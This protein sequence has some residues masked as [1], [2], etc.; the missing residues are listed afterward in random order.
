MSPRAVLVA[1][2]V[3]LAPPVNASD[4]TTGVLATAAPPGPTPELVEMTGQLRLVL[5]RRRPGVLDAAAL[6]ERMSHPSTASL[7][8]LDRA[9][10][11]SVAAYLNGDYEGSVRTLHAILEDLEKMPE[12]RQ[13]FSQWTRAMLRLASTELDLDRRDAANQV[14]DRLVRADPGVQVDPAQHPP[15]L[16][17]LIEA[18]RSRLR[19]SPGAK[20]TVKA[21]ESARV[22]VDGREVGTTPLVVTLARGRYRVTGVRQA[23]H[24]PAVQVDLT[25]GDRSVTLDFTVAEMLLPDKGPGLALPGAERLR[26]LVAAGAF[27]RLDSILAMSLLDDAGA[28]YLVGSLHDVRRGM[29]VREGRVRLSGRSLPSDGAA[30]LADFFVTGKVS[31]PVEP[32]LSISADAPRTGGKSKALGWTAF[33]TGVTMIGLGGV[34]IWQA[35]SSS[36]SYDSA[37]KL[38]QSDGRVLP[39]DQ[40]SYSDH[41]SAGDAANRRAIGIGIGA[42]VCAATTVVLGYLAYRQTGEIGPFRF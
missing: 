11:G 6:R 35:I 38:L 12:G 8:E 9:Y 7:A 14:A 37:Q 29:L 41:L 2:A 36:S 19:S 4:S 31:S 17:R 15:R 13:T 1:L 40:A 16:V 18:A 28:S 39:D 34:A 3:L 24:A 20:L 5:S 42:G 23:I 10:D 32:Y 21:A 30:G 25:G 33:G 27:L 22:F 26:R